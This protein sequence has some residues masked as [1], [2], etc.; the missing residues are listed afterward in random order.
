MFKLSTLVVL[1]LFAAILL[2]AQDA[3]FTEDVLI[4]KAIEMA[5]MEG[6]VTVHKTAI[7]RHDK[8]DAV[9]GSGRYQLD[10]ASLQRP[11][12]VALLEG[13]PVVIHYLPIPGQLP[14]VYQ[15]ALVALLADTGEPLTI[16][17]LRLL[18]DA[19][20]Q[21]FADDLLPETRL[22]ELALEAA[23]LAGLRDILTEQ[24]TLWAK[25]GQ[26][27][28]VT[29]KSTFKV[30]Y[31][32]LIAYIV[33][34]KGAGLPYSG[35]TIVLDARTGVMLE[36]IPGYHIENV[37]LEVTAEVAATPSPDSLVTIAQQIAVREGMTHYGAI[38]SLTMRISDWPHTCNHQQALENPDLP[39]F[40]MAIR[41]PPPSGFRSLKTYRQMTI[42]LNAVTGELLSIEPRFIDPKMPQRSYGTMVCLSKLPEAQRARIIPTLSAD[43]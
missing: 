42:H 29:L 40:I 7:M 21:Y 15:G 27:R 22:N 2:D 25:W 32:Q 13:Q 10:K 28:Y 30:D 14:P 34:I 33:A 24:T 19:P 1:F 20:L 36:T 9:A 41:N 5:G 38:S 16:M 18:E 3:Q 35:L 11:V 4:E 31:P 17:G 8:W 23:R 26:W 12:F 37:S 39:V 6:H 43:H